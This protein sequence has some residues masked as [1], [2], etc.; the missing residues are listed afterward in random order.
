MFEGHVHFLSYSPRFPVWILRG[1]SFVEPELVAMDDLFGYT[2]S[3][4]PKA[5][6]REIIKWIQGLDLTHAV[7]D[8]RRLV[9]GPRHLLCLESPPLSIL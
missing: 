4:P 5:L 3:P 8:P 9:H 6:R 2:P 1:R 7:K